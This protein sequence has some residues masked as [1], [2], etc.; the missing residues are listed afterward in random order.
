MQKIRE[1]VTMQEY[2]STISPS[3]ISLTFS[4]RLLPI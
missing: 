3:L 4:H 2:S 1:V